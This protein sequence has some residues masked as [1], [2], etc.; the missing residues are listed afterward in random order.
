MIFHSDFLWL[1][2]GKPAMAQAYKIIIN[3]GYGFWGLRTQ[4]RDGVEIFSPNPNSHVEYLK[5]IR[6]KF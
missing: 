2:Y 1:S 6:I 3:S 5:V 4:D